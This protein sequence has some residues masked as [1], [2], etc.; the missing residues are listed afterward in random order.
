[1]PGGSDVN[2]PRAR[3]CDL[4]LVD[5]GKHRR[6]QDAGLLE[7]KESYGRLDLI[8]AVVLQH[9]WE[10]LGPSL[11]TA[12]WKQVSGELHFSRTTLDLVVE[13]ATQTAV[14]VRDAAQLSETLPR[15]TTIIVVHVSGPVNQAARRLREFL[16]HRAYAQMPGRPSRITLA[17]GRER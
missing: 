7:R 6:W 11:A 16:S 15:D 8:R 12:A 17:A 4:A 14:V 9:V 13:P 1:M 3:L 10:T 5:R 2:L